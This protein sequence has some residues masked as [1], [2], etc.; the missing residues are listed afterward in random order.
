MITNSLSFANSE[1]TFSNNLR[2]N[3]NSAKCCFQF[4][5]PLLYPAGLRHLSTV[6]SGRYYFLLFSSATQGK[7]I[8]EALK[9]CLRRVCADSNTDSDFRLDMTFRE[10]SAK[11][12]GVS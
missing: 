8:H 3:K 5:N 1:F 7:E 12:Y 10:R 6:N 9:T 2:L 11:G 4:R